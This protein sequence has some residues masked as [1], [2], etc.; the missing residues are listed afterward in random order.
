M[1]EVKRTRE[2]RNRGDAKKQPKKNK[3]KR[4]SSTP[5]NKKKSR[6]TFRRDLLVPGVK[7]KDIVSPAVVDRK[8]VRFYL[9][10]YFKRFI[11]VLF[12][13]NNI[14][15]LCQDEL[16]EFSN[17]LKEFQESDCE[18]LAVSTES[19]FAHLAYV[20]N[21]YRG[22]M[23]KNCSFPLISD[24]LASIAKNYGMLHEVSGLCHRG[25]VV[26]DPSG[27]VAI[28]EYSD[29]NRARNASEWLNKVR[30]L[31]VLHGHEKCYMP[32][33]WLPGDDILVEEDEDEL[34]DETNDATTLMEKLKV[35]ST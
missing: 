27:V 33:G 26:I 4:K 24:K 20:K 11:L 9:S 28:V 7:A 35:S 29:F 8:I 3:D 34:E 15:I 23:C 19:H 22:G 12:Y 5:T 31:R 32:E 2:H 18:I 16:R 1:E 21:E 6:S 10:S 14:P 13:P 25:T 17:K 30:A